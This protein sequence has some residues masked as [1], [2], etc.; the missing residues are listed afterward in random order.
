MSTILQA[1]NATSG[2][3]V[4]SDTAG[5]LQIQ[6]GS[7]PTTAI[8]VDTSQNVGIGVTPSAWYSSAKALQVGTGSQFAIVNFSSGQSGLVFNAYYNGSNYIYQNSAPAG[9]FDFNNA[10]TGGYAW[11][12]AASGTAGNAISFSEAMRIDSSGNLLVGTTSNSNGYRT[13]FALN[14]NLT[15]SAKGWNDLMSGGNELD[16][17]A[18]F[19]GSTDFYFN[20][21]SGTAN[22]GNNAYVTSYRFWNGNG[23]SG[24]YVP[25]YGGAYTN[26]SDYRLKSDVKL[27]SD[28]AL[29]KII[30]LTPKTY[31]Y[32]NETKTSIGFIAHEV[33]EFIP[34]SVS[35]VKDGID[36]DGDP[37]YQGIDYS[38][39]T[40][41]LVKAIQE[42]NVKVDA[43]AAQITA[44][45]A[46][47][48]L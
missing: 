37:E 44:L 38:Q 11:R 1:G 18:G 22:G 12:I 33:Q 36:K 42:L 4:S 26:A 3:V 43:Q 2:A 25:I 27:L 7:T 29:E 20:Y 46:K 28:G 34:E 8:T 5:S 6:T 16:C 39:I 17:T 13:I 14:N 32:Q 23:G 41:I 31:V 15:I 24:A 40:T 10:A 47:V 45:Q 21:H 19:T 48:G 35:G 30:A 9:V